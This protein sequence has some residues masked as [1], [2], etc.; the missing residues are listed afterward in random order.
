[1]ALIVPE[2]YGDL[3]QASFVG[4]AV[5]LNSGATLQDNT[6]EGVPGDTV[7]FPKWDLIGDQLDDLTTG[8]AMTPA[9]LGQSDSTATIKEAGKAVEIQD[10]DKLTALGDG[11]SEAI[12]Q[13]GIM[14]AR[15]VDAD[16]I[17][18]AVAAG[19]NV[20][21][22]TAGVKASWSVVVDMIA[23]FGDDWDPS[24]FAGLFIRSEQQADLFKDPQFV[25]ASKLGGGDTV[26]KRGQLG[27]IGGLGVFVSNRLPANK[28]A[29]LE[30]NSLGALYKRRPVVETDRDILKRS[31]VVTTNVHYAVKRLKDSGVCV[32]TFS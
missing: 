3:A 30:V 12:R 8:V 23:T 25:D 14:A 29:L 24:Q 7:H 18:A 22:P 17:T 31:D 4:K 26:V 21:T 1:M 16:L 2:V 9:V 32:A 5:V 11:Q 20:V 10:A 19:S 27:V 6:L 13:F 15:K 28:V